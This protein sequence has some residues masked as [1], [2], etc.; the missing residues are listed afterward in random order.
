MIEHS[1]SDVRV[2]RSQRRGDPRI[3]IALGDFSYVVVL[4]ERRE[5]VVLWTAYF[6]DQAHRRE[7]LR[8]EC[9]RAKTSWGRP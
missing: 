8:K 4:A 6:V 2:W 3:V 1:P 9:M 5:Y 7:K